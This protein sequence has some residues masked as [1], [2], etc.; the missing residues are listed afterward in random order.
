MP[1]FQLH[2]RANRAIRPP[3]D[4]FWTPHIHQFWDGLSAEQ[5]K[6]KVMNERGRQGLK[7]AERQ[8]KREEA[9]VRLSRRLREARIRRHPARRRS[10]YAQPRMTW[11]RAPL[12]RSV[13]LQFAVSLACHAAPSALRRIEFLRAQFYTKDK[14]DHGV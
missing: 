6:D 5:M 14:R 9:P 1:R 8:S 11:A 7:A 10:P 12:A 3:P 4:A 2:E 13:R